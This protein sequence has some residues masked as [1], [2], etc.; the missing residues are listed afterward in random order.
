MQGGLQV[1]RMNPDAILVFIEPPS[2]EVLETRLRGRAT[3]D[4]KPSDA[5][6]KCKT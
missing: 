3:E 6:C 1:R 4:E 5:S 2:L